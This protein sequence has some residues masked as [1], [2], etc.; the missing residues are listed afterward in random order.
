MKK[1]LTK[2]DV[3]R[4]VNFIGLYEGGKLKWSTILA[5]LPRL[6]DGARTFSRVTLSDNDVI[7]QARTDKNRRL[8][9]AR[10]CGSALPNK[11]DRE[12]VQRDLIIELSLRNDTLHERVVQLSF[13]ALKFGMSEADLNQQLPP[14][15]RLT[16]EDA[17]KRRR[18]NAD[19]HQ[20]R[21][22]ARKA[23]LKNMKDAK[24]AKRARTKMHPGALHMPA[25]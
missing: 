12:A 13:N 25:D 22:D 15:A 1:Q 14:P 24:E 17:E 21:V 5:V 6:L 4:I 19:A 3:E 9:L 20:R 11:R 23:N 8:E 16:P 7:A 18:E 10:A 2:E